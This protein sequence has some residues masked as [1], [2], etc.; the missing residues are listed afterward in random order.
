MQ[1]QTLKEL[2]HCTRLLA[3]NIGHYQTSFGAL[4]EDEMVALMHTGAADDE[5]ARLMADGL[6][7]LIGVLGAAHAAHAEDDIC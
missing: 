1:S 4:P 6:K 3:L 5:Q 7:A 2:A